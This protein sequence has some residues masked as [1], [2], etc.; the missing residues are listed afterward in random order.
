MIP[1]LLLPNESGD[2]SSVETAETVLNGVPLP[3][4]ESEAGGYR[5]SPL[6]FG[7]IVDEQVIPEETRQE[8]LPEGKET[9]KAGP[10]NLTEWQ[11]FF[12]RI[13]LRG[14][15]DGYIALAFRGIDEDL[16]SE[17]DL[18]KLKLTEEERGRIAVPFAEYA[19]KSAFARKHGRKVV[20]ATESFEAMAT[21]ALW[22][23]RVNRISRKYKPQGQKGKAAHV[24]SRQAESNGHDPDT[25]QPDGLRIFNPNV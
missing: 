19:N 5:E 2:T 8:I 4:T 1:D 17:R 18:A 15:T 25:I 22:A 6:G 9:P 3:T 14:L 7:A 16:L 21:L 13:V 23:G 11:R 12:S 20:A 24:S 10:P